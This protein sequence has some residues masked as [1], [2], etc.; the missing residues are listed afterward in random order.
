MEMFLLPETIFAALVVWMD[1]GMLCNTKIKGKMD[2]RQ[3]SPSCHFVSLAYELKEQNNR[4]CT[5][6]LVWRQTLP[7]PCFSL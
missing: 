7:F 2:E 1:M 3:S 5:H 6:F 4:P